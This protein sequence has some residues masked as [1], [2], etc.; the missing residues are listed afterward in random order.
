MGFIARLEALSAL[1]LAVPHVILVT[2][3]TAL[4]ALTVSPDVPLI[5]G[6]VALSAPTVFPRVPLVSVVPAS[7]AFATNP[8]VACGLV[9]RAVT[10]A[11]TIPTRPI[12]EP[13]K[14]LHV[15]GGKPFQPNWRYQESAGGAD[16]RSCGPRL[17][18]SHIRHRA[19]FYR[20]SA[21]RWP[22]LS[23]D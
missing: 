20:P 4:H 19:V 12:V 9:N 13:Q 3:C 21:R 16:P 15:H 7:R 1:A 11:S 22:G 6:S 23:T 5:A 2:L 14:T 10:T 17:F 18:P 8:C